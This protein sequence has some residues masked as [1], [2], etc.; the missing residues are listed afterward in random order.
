MEVL[1]GYRENCFYFFPFSLHFW[2]SFF[3]FGKMYIY[4]RYQFVFEDRIDY[5]QEH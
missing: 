1:L 4:S 2:C 5:T 3:V